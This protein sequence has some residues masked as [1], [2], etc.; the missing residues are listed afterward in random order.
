VSTQQLAN[1]LKISAQNPPP[2]NATPTI[3]RAWA[4][5]ITSHTPLAVNVPFSLAGFLNEVNQSSTYFASTAVSFSSIKLV[6]SATPLTSIP[7][8]TISNLR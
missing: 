3:M 2:A 4:E 6:L 8:M 7:S 5:G 1:I